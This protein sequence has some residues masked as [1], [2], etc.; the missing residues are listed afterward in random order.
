M[1]TLGA[2]LLCIFYV[3]G[4]AHST[5]STFSLFLVNSTSGERKG[6]KCTHHLMLIL[7][8][9]SAKIFVAYM[10]YI[11]YFGNTLFP[12]NLIWDSREME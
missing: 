12:H 8:L 5:L 4:S 2:I 10:F 11:T 3:P 1:Q 9:F 6:V 7:T